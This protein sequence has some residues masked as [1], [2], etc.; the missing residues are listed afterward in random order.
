MNYVEPAL[1]E[2]GPSE[3]VVLQKNRN[4]QIKKIE[5]V[6]SSLASKSNFPGAERQVSL[7]IAKGLYPAH[8][9][10]DFKT[11]PLFL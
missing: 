7:T 1:S 2:K 6:F 9:T 11:I 5:R 4:F 3:P 8:Q 10:K